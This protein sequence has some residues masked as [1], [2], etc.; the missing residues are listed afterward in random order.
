MRQISG[1]CTTFACLVAV[2]GMASMA[3]A[4]PAAQEAGRILQ[5]SG[6][7]GGLIVHIGCGDGRLTAALRA[8]DSYLVHGLDKNIDSVERARKHVRSLGLYG[9]VSVEPWQGG[10]LP[11]ADNLVSLLV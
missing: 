10:Y 1:F 4:Q 7:K 8:K 2:L 5:T 11:Y 3:T 6:V 9:K